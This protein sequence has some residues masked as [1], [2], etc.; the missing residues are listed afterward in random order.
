MHLHGAQLDHHHGPGLAWRED[1]V[2]GKAK[3]RALCGERIQMPPT[4]ADWTEARGPSRHVPA[5]LD[6]KVKLSVGEWSAGLR[7]GY[8]PRWAGE[9]D[10][11]ANL[12]NFSFCSVQGGV[13]ENQCR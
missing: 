2:H 10:G 13:K 9:R 7:H 5:E 11:T 1:N 3:C 12:K 8:F 6:L 4:Q